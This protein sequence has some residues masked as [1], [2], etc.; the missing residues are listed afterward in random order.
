MRV[1]RAVHPRDSNVAAGLHILGG[2]YIH[3]KLQSAPVSPGPCYKK[4]LH[5][6]IPPTNQAAGPAADRLDR[7]GRTG[8]CLARA[9][10]WCVC[11]RWLSASLACLFC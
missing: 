10:G 6:V 9:R 4:S 11:H 1:P 3:S 8:T 2:G 7:P 5:D